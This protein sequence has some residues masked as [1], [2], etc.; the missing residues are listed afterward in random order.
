MADIQRDA[1]SEHDW[2]IRAYYLAVLDGWSHTRIADELR[3]PVDVVRA[4]IELERQRRAV[5]HAGLREDM[6]QEFEGRQP[7]A[8]EG[9]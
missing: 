2:R 3:Q 5:A 9:A 7:K 4:A 6:R 8:A 1:Y